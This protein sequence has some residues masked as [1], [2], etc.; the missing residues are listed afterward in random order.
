MI[1]GTGIDL[2]DVNRMKDGFVR[3]KIFSAKAA[4]LV[5]G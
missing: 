1:A 4:L 5:Y 3:F 2:V